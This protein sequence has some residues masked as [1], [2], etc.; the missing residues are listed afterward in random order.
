MLWTI[1]VLC[2]IVILAYFL[3]KAAKGT[4]FEH[5]CPCT[6]RIEQLRWQEKPDDPEA[7]AK[8]EQLW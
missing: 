8:K 7:Q 5:S 2:G 1:L 6:P 3:R 4:P